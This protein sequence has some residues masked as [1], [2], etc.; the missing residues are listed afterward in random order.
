[1]VKPYVATENLTLYCA[2]VLEGL[3]ALEPGSVQTC[4]TSPPYF[5]LRDYG[6]C[7]KRAADAASLYVR[8]IG[9]DRG[10]GPNGWVYKVRR[11]VPGAAAG[12]PAGV[13]LRAHE[14]VLWFYCRMGA[15]G[16]QR[17]LELTV[18]G[19]AAAG[20]QLT[21]TVRGYDDNGRGVAIADATVALAGATTQTGAGGAATL[22]APA[23]PGRYVAAASAPGLVAAFP[24]EVT[25]R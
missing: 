8:R 18:P 12:D 19:A 24:V 22:T 11:K 14:R 1:L 2:D 3:A 21:A 5:A 13:R 20:A 16:C 25:V 23:A 6:R 9:P 17:T 10:A 15:H 7:G 4:I